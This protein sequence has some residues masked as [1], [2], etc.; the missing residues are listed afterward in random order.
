MRVGILALALM[1]DGLHRAGF[2]WLTGKQ[3]MD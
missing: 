1:M 3:G 2:G